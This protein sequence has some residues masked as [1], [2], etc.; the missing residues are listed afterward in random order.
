M[1]TFRR[2]GAQDSILATQGQ[3]IEGGTLRLFV[4]RLADELVW[5]EAF[6]GLESAAKVAGRD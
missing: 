1:A 3:R 4:P 6:E 2:F 5:R